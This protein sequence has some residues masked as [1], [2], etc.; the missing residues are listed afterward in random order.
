MDSKHCDEITIALERF[1]ELYEMPAA[2]TLEA[3]HCELSSATLSQHGGDIQCT[4]GDGALRCFGT[5]PV[6][7]SWQP[8][9]VG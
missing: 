5:L 8:F 3:V 4:P 1:L 9:N 6:N 2:E 7:N